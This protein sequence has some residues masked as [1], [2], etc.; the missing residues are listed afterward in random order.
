VNTQ[1]YQVQCIRHPGGVLITIARLNHKVLARMLVDTGAAITVVVPRTAARLGLP[2]DKP[3]RTMSIGVAHATHTPLIPVFNLDC[4]QAGDVEVTDLEIGVVG[5][6]P[7]LRI[8]GA[9]GVNFLARFRPTFEF[10]T[11]TLLLHPLPNLRS[12]RTWG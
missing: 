11:A 12:S 3:H 10:D 1:D 8:D 4:L 9:L 2:L 6:P 7:R 5:F